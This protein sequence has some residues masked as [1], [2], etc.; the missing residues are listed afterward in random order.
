MTAID[1]HHF[2]IDDSTLPPWNC[3]V[4]KREFARLK[5]QLGDDQQ[6]RM[7]IVRYLMTSGRT[8]DMA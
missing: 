3:R 5:Q 4:A 7:Q 8:L 6:V 2:V 1:D